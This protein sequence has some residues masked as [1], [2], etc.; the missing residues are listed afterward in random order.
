MA[1][2]GVEHYQDK[3]QATTVAPAADLA[4]QAPNQPAQLFR[5][6]GRKYCSQM[7]SCAEATYFLKNCP[8]VK[9]DG[10]GDGVPCEQQWCRP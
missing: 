9:M 2:K 4:L 1:W 8:G 3:R 7:T 6:D 10:N 5:C